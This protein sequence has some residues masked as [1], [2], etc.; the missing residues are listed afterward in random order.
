MRGENSNGR[1]VD[2]NVAK[3]QSLNIITS[4]KTSPIR[5]EDR[6]IVSG[7]LAREVYLLSWQNAIHFAAATSTFYPNAFIILL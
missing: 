2:I 1:F 3:L 7:A 5:R 6:W 4:M